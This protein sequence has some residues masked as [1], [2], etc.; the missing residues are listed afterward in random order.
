MHPD[1]Q[2]AA[3]PL[4]GR[5]GGA[6]FNPGAGGSALRQRGRR[7]AGPFLDGIDLIQHQLGIV[8]LPHRNT[9]PEEQRLSLRQLFAVLGVGAPEAHHL[10]AAGHI[11]HGKQRQQVAP[12][13]GSHL[14]FGQYAEDIDPC[15]IVGGVGLGTL[16]PRDAHR[17][18]AVVKGQV[19][20]HGVA[21]KVHP[22]DLLFEGQQLGVGV[23]LPRGKLIIG[24]GAA[25]PEKGKLPAG[26]ITALLG[27]G[28][29]KGGIVFQHL[30][31]V[32]TQPVQSAAFDEAFHPAAVKVACGVAAAEFHKVGKGAVLLPFL[33][34]ILDDRAPHILNGQQPEPDALWGDGKD[35]IALV[36][37]GGQHRDFQPGT[38]LDVFHQLGGG[39]QHAGHQGRHVFPGVMP[40]EVGGL[41]RHHRIAGGMGFI[42]GVGRKA[43]HFIK[44]AVRHR[45]RDAVLGA[46]RNEVP[47]FLFHDVG[48]LLAHG[49]AHQ[50]GLPVAVPCQ[51]PA[52]L[53]DLL[54]VDDAAV[55]DPQ[56]RLQQRGL[57][58][59]GGGVLLIADVLGD[60]IHRAGPV[61]RNG[62]G[63]VLDGAGPKLGEHLPHPARFQLEHPGGIPP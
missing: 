44:D 38:L 3:L 54:L 61:Q 37:I 57:V 56:N 52:D 53:H 31:A 28:I 41:V 40:L 39:I 14:F 35:H 22:R 13:G 6:R 19:L 21:G 42:E 17:P 50:V 4:G 8:L 59:D 60:G 36:D 63:E 27:D 26:K 11:L 34:D 7:C 30:P 12:L 47:P 45:L 25:L 43:A 24:G 46:A 20:A 15:V 5:P 16:Q 58:A 49:T 10:H 32:G 62:G 55:G 1:K 9:A 48:L 51:L 29:R 2:P 33:Q 23:F 18:V